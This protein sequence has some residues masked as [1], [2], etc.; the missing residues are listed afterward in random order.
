M[1]QSLLCLQRV[2]EDYPDGAWTIPSVRNRPDNVWAIPGCQRPIAAAAFPDTY[3][4]A[5]EERRRSRQCA[6]ILL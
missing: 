6:I 3:S 5:G 1:P 2:P 4:Y